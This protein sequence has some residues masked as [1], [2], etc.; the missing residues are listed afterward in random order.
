MRD[1]ITCWLLIIGLIAVGS[2]PHTGGAQP[3]A[4]DA[5]GDHARLIPQ[6]RASVG[7]A[8]ADLQLLHDLVGTHRL[9][10]S[11][12]QGVNLGHRAVDAPV[13]RHLAPQLHEA[14]PLGDQLLEGAQRADA[15]RQRDVRHQLQAQLGAA[16]LERRQRQQAGRQRPHQRLGL[17]RVDQAPLVHPLALDALPA[18]VVPDVPKR[19]RRAAR[20]L[21]G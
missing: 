2:L 4:P 11:H 17:A 3:M 7:V 14:H 15:R 9:R 10:G 12:E 19:V 5:C 16:V 13:R 18:A 21:G 8:A 6:R 20:L 1:R